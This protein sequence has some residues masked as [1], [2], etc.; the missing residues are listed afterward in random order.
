MGR[1]P[2]ALGLRRLGPA[3]LLG[4][5][6][7]CG[8]DDGDASP[9]SVATDLPPD[10]RLSELSDAQ[11]QEL[12]RGFLH[13]LGDVL[14]GQIERIQCGVAAVGD[15]IAVSMSGQVRFDLA[16]CEQRLAECLSRLP[17]VADA[18]S[19]TPPSAN[20]DCG[21]P[22]ATQPLQTCDASVA[23]YERCWSAVI[24]DSGEDVVELTACDQAL[25]SLEA[26]EAMTTPGVRVPPPECAALI[27]L[28]PQISVP[29]TR[30]AP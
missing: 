13:G 11:R 4:L 2:G 9:A 17:D 18:G 20:L 23:Q 25:A 7:G 1:A 6:L 29:G 3:A 30:P 16:L 5:W 27:E 12:C 14:D 22:A 24:A 21:A 28:C 15:T 19:V 8:G 10:A 26:S